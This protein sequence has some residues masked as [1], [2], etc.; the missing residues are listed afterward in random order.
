M[1][2]PLLVAKRTRIVVYDEVSSNM[3][4]VSSNTSHEDTIIVVVLFDTTA[5]ALS[6]Y[7]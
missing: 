3:S 7:M 4:H 1:P 6:T 2:S 5:G